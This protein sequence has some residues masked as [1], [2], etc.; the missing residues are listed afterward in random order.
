MTILRLLSGKLL[1][2][3]QLEAKFTGTAEKEIH[4]KLPEVAWTWLPDGN[5]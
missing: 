4:C 1:C 2:L 3:R 5:I